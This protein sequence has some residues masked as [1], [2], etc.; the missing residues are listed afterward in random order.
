MPQTR[1]RTITKSSKV[2]QL[3][4]GKRLPV[5]ISTPRGKAAR[6][7][8]QSPS[9]T[10]IAQDAIE[11]PQ[12]LGPSHGVDRATDS[13]ISDAPAAA[14]SAMGQALGLDREVSTSVT[15]EGGD[16][17]QHR[18][19]VEA[20]PADLVME[21]AAAGL[22]G[23]QAELTNEDREPAREGDAVELTPADPVME[24]AAA[25]LLGTPAELTN[26]DREPARE[27]DAMEL[28]PND[29]GM[30][31]AEEPTEADSLD[32]SSHNSGLV[33][34]S[35]TSQNP[36][37]I[38]DSN[39]VGFNY[40]Y[41]RQILSYYNLLDLFE[42]SNNVPETYIGPHIYDC[43]DR[44]LPYRKARGQGLQQQQRDAHV[45]STIKI[46][47]AMINQVQSRYDCESVST[48][49]GPPSLLHSEIA[50]ISVTIALA[51]VL[52]W[53]ASEYRRQLLHQRREATQ[54]SEE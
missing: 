14:D 30:E 20:T 33:G 5:S 40:N 3:R 47:E 34:V 44:Q 19:S 12:P 28:T 6:V 32:D 23:T 37:E 35:G 29:S 51:E 25:G 22:L 39:E 2:R 45:G 11:H 8:Q 31:N 42:E 13:P 17:V 10:A 48:M 46:L 18:D 7:H 21:G 26:E 15:G 53:H 41:A 1:S 52:S 4:S 36:I 16:L 49:E 27:G 50:A 38:E 43:H 24:G 9:A 54:D